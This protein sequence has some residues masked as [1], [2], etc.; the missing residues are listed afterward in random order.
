MTWSTVLGWLASTSGGRQGEEEPFREWWFV[1]RSRLIAV[2]ATRQHLYSAQDLRP[3]DYQ[4][5]HELRAQ[6][7]ES[8]ETRC[9][10]FR[11]RKDPAAYLAAL[12][13]QLL[14]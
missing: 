12:E 14:M 7:Q 9:L 5:W 3:G 11:F 6:L 10:Q 2:V 8:E 1:V 13:A 4:R